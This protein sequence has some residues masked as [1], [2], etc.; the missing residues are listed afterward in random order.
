MI[1][2]YVMIIYLMYYTLYITFCLNIMNEFTK[3]NRIESNRIEYRRFKEES[4]F[5]SQKFIIRLVCLVV[6]LWW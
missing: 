4:N 3:K 5:N 2:L 1:I 6:L